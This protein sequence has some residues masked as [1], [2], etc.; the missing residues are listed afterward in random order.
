MISWDAQFILLL[1]QEMVYESLVLSS[2]ARVTFPV[3]IR[4]T[5]RCQR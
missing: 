4:A 2:Y 5:N 3:E 1:T